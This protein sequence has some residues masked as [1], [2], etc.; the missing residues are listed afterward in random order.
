MVTKPNT[1]DEK[2]LI[3]YLLGQADPEEQEQIEQR[4][5][6]D[7]EFHDHLR[8]IERDLI[9]QYVHGELHD[10][11]EFEKQFLSSPQRRQKVEFAR[12]LREALAATPAEQR[13]AVPERPKRNAAGWFSGWRLAAAMVVLLI[14]GW[15]L[16][17]W[18]QR[19]A[20]SRIADTS[21]PQP[22]EHGTKP[23]PEPGPDATL[24]PGDAT[25]IRVATFVL[26]PTLTRDGGET[27]TLVIAPDLDVRLQLSLEAGDY[28]TYRVD[29]RTAAGD[30]VWRQDGLTIVRT[31][32]GDAVVITVPASRLS[33]AFYTIRISGISA[34]SEAEPVA[35]YYFRV[36]KR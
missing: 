23:A 15:L 18:P 25:P 16:A 28:D 31:S 12:A 9:D 2:L 3:Q 35:S 34:A 1:R 17:P 30:G 19:G 8:A 4:Y 26:L 21:P 13:T 33:D 29:M 10:A 14:G 20:T 32:S 11:E 7:P 6:I 24:P 22:A 36:Q 27:R 5:L